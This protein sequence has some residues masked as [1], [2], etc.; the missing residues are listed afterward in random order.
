MVKTILSSPMQY[1]KMG[2]GH[3]SLDVI[4]PILLTLG[5]TKELATGGEKW[6]KRFEDN[7]VPINVANDTDKC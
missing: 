4:L 5:M 6:L 2:Q 7:C 1:S 3:K